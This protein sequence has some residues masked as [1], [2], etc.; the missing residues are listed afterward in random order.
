[1]KIE[2]IRASFAGRS[3]RPVTTSIL[4]DDYEEALR[5]FDEYGL[6]PDE[7]FRLVFGLGMAE[8]KRQSRT[9]LSDDDAIKQLNRIEGAFVGMRH[10]AFLLALDNEKME[11]ARNGWIRENQALTGRVQQ[12]LNEIADLRGQPRPAPPPMS[13]DDQL[14]APA[15]LDEEEKRDRNKR[16]WDRF[17]GR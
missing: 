14:E 4:D 15:F 10:K 16:F 17:L 7:G 13:A 5:L 6:D 3:L 8:F 9:D 1:M 2:E 12:L 11:L